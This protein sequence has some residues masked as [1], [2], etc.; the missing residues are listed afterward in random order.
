[1][2]SER[3]VKIEIVGMPKGMLPLYTHTA[4]LA[5][6]E[7]LNKKLIERS[8]GRANVGHVQALR[9]DFCGGEHANGRCSLEWTS[10][11]AQFANFQQNNPFSNTYNPGWKDHPNFCWNNNQNSNSNQGM[12]QSQHDLFQRKPSKL[13]ETLQNFIKLT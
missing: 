6:V 4:L 7:L 5:Q 12:Q 8:L 11:E 13:E 1:M 2:K 9:C 3:S 10:E